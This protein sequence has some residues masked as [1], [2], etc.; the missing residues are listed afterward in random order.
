MADASNNPGLVSDCDTLVL[1]RDTL[2]GSAALNWSA[3]RPIDLWEGVTAAGSPQRVTELRSLSEGTDGRDTGG[4][5]QPR[6]SGGSLLLGR[7]QLTGEIPAELGRLSNLKVLYI[8]FNDLGGTIPD[9][10]SSLANLE[11]LFL[12]ET[13]L[14]GPI[15]AWLGGL[16][17]LEFLILPGNELTGSIPSELGSL[18]NLKWLVLDKNQLTGRI[19][20]ELGSLVNLEGLH[21]SHNQLTGPI[22]VELG[23][24]ANL[25]QL[26]L[27]RNPVDRPDSRRTGRTSHARTP[28]PVGQ[29]VN[30][31]HPGRVPGRGRKRSRRHRSA[32]L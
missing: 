9:E 26:Y 6:Q 17:N 28:V 21:L 20:T 12:Q 31:V 32:V 30:W 1:A 15:P 25:E 19:P 22:P 13:N 24:L 7:N 5:G 27:S 14:T 10:V 16:S 18:S 4:V 2:A 29:P 23:G 8:S 11:Q 3:N